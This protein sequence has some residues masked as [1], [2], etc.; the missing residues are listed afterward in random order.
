MKYFWGISYFQPSSMSEYPGT[1][2]YSAK[3]LLSSFVLVSTEKIYIDIS[4]YIDSS[5]IRNI[6]NI[7]NLKS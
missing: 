3:D 1:Q 2:K 4:H 6:Y 5:Q 7:F